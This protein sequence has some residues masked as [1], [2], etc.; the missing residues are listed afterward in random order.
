[1]N[2]V[3]T[4][5]LI[6]HGIECHPLIL[7]KSGSLVPSFFLSGVSE[8]NAEL[9]PADD[10]L[11][12]KSGEY[13]AIRPIQNDLWQ[14]IFPGVQ[15]AFVEPKRI[16]AP[17][18][19][20]FIVVPPDVQDAVQNLDDLQ[21]KNLIL[22]LAMKDHPSSTELGKYSVIRGLYN[23]RYVQVV[24]EK[25]TLEL[26]ATKPS[27][28][29]LYA[30]INSLYVKTGL[31]KEL[32][33][34]PSALLQCLSED[35]DVS[36]VLEV[37]P[38]YLS[39][40]VRIWGRI[41]PELFQVM[42]FNSTSQSLITENFGSLSQLVSYLISDGY[43]NEC[44]ADQKKLI[45]GRII[46][47]Q[48][49][50]PEWASKGFGRDPLS[51]P[52]LEEIS[53]VR[54]QRLGH[55]DVIYADKS[56]RVLKRIVR[57]EITVSRISIRHWLDQA[58]SY[59]SDKAISYLIWGLVPQEQSEEHTSDSE[60]VAKLTIYPP[61]VDSICDRR[62]LMCQLKELCF[63]RDQSPTAAFISRC[64]LYVIIEIIETNFVRKAQP[65]EKYERFITAVERIK[66]ILFSIHSREP[67]AFF[68]EMRSE[69]IAAELF[70]HRAFGG[71]AL[72]M[73]QPKGVEFL[74]DLQCEELNN[75]QRLIRLLN[76]RAYF[77]ETLRPYLLSG[78]LLSS[79]WWLKG[80][81]LEYSEG[82]WYAQRGANILFVG[83]HTRD[84]L[85]QRIKDHVIQSR[86]KV[87]NDTETQ[88]DEFFYLSK[89]G[90]RYILNE[91]LS[92]GVQESGIDPFLQRPM[93]R[94]LNLINGG[95]GIG[96]E[97]FAE[98][99]ERA[100][101]ET[102][103]FR[104]D[105]SL[106]LLARVTSIPH[107]VITF[108]GTLGVR[109]SGSESDPF[110]ALWN[111][112]DSQTAAIGSVAYSWGAMLFRY[113]CGFDSGIRLHQDSLYLPEHEIA[114][115]NALFRAICFKDKKPKATTTFFEFEENLF[116]RLERVAFDDSTPE[117]IISFEDSEWDDFIVQAKLS[118][119]LIRDIIK[120]RLAKKSYSAESSH[121]SFSSFLKAS[122]DSSLQ[123]GTIFL[124]QGESLFARAFEAYV[125]DCCYQCGMI[126]DFLV[127]GTENSDRL[128]E[129]VY[130][131]GVERYQI[132][133]CFDALW[134]DSDFQAVLTK[135]S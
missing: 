4:P 125:Q 12:I 20:D 32:K 77:L 117:K 21:F 5:I 33:P 63:Y 129:L 17:L 61:D 111:D 88:R 42:I 121:L 104:L 29:H 60:A 36:K 120:Y 58:Y 131:E 24:L 132:A 25:V 114:S 3:E 95:G 44:D 64:V 46:A 15:T 28:K 112:Y 126:D 67:L 118:D 69:C 6:K 96:R 87:I 93:K 70:V 50:I 18:I 91:D 54:C 80:Y 86:V 81:Q 115:I 10:F 107:E 23:Y 30:F 78:D 109:C 1:M 73:L 124:I 51:F 90:N 116:D 11:K 14:R 16:E 27:M 56:L 101:S 22:N 100:E 53:G 55:D 49:E 19:D 99:E 134:L 128:G 85:D 105:Q 66:D 135:E 106:G 7:N 47:L 103:F 48:S 38:R 133:K 122:S 65:G 119:E 43:I 26:L 52:S 110:F 74:E 72:S 102:V 127:Y 31:D 98:V 62:Q 34:D 79:R 76:D 97:A 9:L 89:N 108:N 39:K 123:R 82:G 113:L 94:K 68:V 2:L 13:V 40:S 45:E 130:P 41:E 83:S 8:E 92:N 75:K 35:Q 59:E 37:L 84:Q 71:S 57:S